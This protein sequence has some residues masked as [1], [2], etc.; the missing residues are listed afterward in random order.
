MPLNDL[1]GQDRAVRILGGMLKT[2]RIVPAYLFAGP[3]G[4]GKTKAAFSFIKAMNCEDASSS[5]EGNFCGTCRSCRH[6]DSLFHPEM[7]VMTP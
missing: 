7:K 3:R 6:T 1:M 2:G 5:A 4:V